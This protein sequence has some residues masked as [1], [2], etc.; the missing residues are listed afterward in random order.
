MALLSVEN[1]SISF[2]SRDGIVNAVNNISYEIN[3]GETVAIVGE[4]GS[5]KS[6]S[7]YSLLGLV[8]TPPGE[9]TAGKAI[10]EGKDLFQCSKAELQNIRGNRIAMIFQDPM[11]SL[12]P[13]LNIGS[14][15][16]EALQNHSSI[17]KKEAKLKA[18]D[19][20]TEVG[21]SD[22]PQR[23][24]QYPHEF[25]GG[26]RQRVMIAMALMTEPDLLIA[27][28][29]TTALDVTI[30]AQIFELLSALQKKRNIA[31]L[32][33]T[34][35]LAVVAQIADRVLVMNKGE[36]VEQGSTSD[37][38]NNTQHDYTRKLL[39]AIP[40]S[41]KPAEYAFNNNQEEVLSIQNLTTQYSTT[42]GF[43]SK[44]Q[45][46]NA[47]IDVSLKLHKGEIL[48]LVGESGCGKSTLSKTILQLVKA[49]SGS[50]KLEGIELTTLNKH[51]L[52][53]TRKDL[54][55]IFQDPYSSLNPRM[56]VFD[57]LLEPL[58]LHSNLNKVA[59]NQRIAELMQ[60]VGL[61]P[62]DIR[63]YPHEFS[64]GQRQRI[65]IAR[66]LAVSPKVIIADEPVSALDVTIQAQI[67]KLLLG[68]VKKYQ[69]SIIFVSHDLSVIRYLCDRTAVMNAGKIIELNNTEDVFNN[70]QHEYTKKLIGAIPTT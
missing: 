23:L 64:G 41:A 62:S 12:N 16:I 45:T 29:P 44:K 66:A 61:L 26:M 49:T 54:Q 50:I 2:H 37:I 57:A 20:L 6:V 51:A 18:I 35:D 42:G 34:H 21:I 10:F 48:G 47:V 36:I 65:A 55:I 9:I 1:L 56:S 68:L 5:G 24:K 14:Q 52:K 69:L 22:V 31:I 28:E 63:K 25:S 67:M 17:S 38:F 39:A 46:M 30:Q 13:Y 7:C 59:L 15:L 43:F 27:D 60:E 3:A 58:K 33:V 4:S 19:A 11:T 8:P 53:N 70:P 32:F 40:A